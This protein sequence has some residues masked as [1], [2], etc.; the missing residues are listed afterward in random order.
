MCGTLYLPT[1]SRRRMASGKASTNNVMTNAV[2]IINSMFKTVRL[3]ILLFFCSFF[4]L[5][6]PLG[7]K[8]TKEIPY[9][10]SEFHSQFPNP[11]PS[12]LQGLCCEY[13][14]VWGIFRARYQTVRKQ[15]PSLTCQRALV[16]TLLCYTCF[17][18]FSMASL[19]IVPTK[20]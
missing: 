4:L 16:V 14:Q 18:P 9:L 19:R 1:S 5:P 10:A 17:L 2:H 3:S 13:P 7:L 11:Y 15:T 12:R 6:F 20:F 8:T